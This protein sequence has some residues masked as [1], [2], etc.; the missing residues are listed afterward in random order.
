MTFSD[1][2]RC[3][4]HVKKYHRLHMISHPCDHSLAVCTVSRWFDIGEFRK[5]VFSRRSQS[6]RNLEWKISKVPSGCCY[7]IYPGRQSTAGVGLGPG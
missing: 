2:V 4:D 7:S 1:S 3:H 5:T 6:G